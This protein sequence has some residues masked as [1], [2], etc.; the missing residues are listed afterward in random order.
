M[1]ETPMPPREETLDAN[2]ETGL[3]QRCKD[4]EREVGLIR[5][6]LLSLGEAHNLLVDAV[7]QHT[8]NPS[9]HVYPPTDAKPDTP[10]G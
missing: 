3:M 6:Q 4:L 8:R 1:G 9:V 5:M 2:P 10:N 7:M